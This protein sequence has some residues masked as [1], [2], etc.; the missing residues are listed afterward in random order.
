MFLSP[1]RRTLFC[2]VLFFFCFLFS[3]GAHCVARAPK[4]NANT[5]GKNKTRNLELGHLRR[6]LAGK[7]FFHDSRNFYGP[8]ARKAPTIDAL[9]LGR[10]SSRFE[11][12]TLGNQRNGTAAQFDLRHVEPCDAP[13]A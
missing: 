12:P 7:V 9:R 6:P 10:A 2:F 1:L 3:L 11:P 13:D 8:N 4:S 5:G